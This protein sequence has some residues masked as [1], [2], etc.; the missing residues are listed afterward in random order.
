M[1]DSR[2]FRMSPSA[3]ELNAHEMVC[4]GKRSEAKSAGVSL[5]F[6]QSTVKTEGGGE[7]DP[8]YVMDTGR[9][10]RRYSTSASRRR[11]SSTPIPGKGET[12]INYS[13][14][15]GIRLTTFDSAAEID[16]LAEETPSPDRRPTPPQSRYPRRQRGPVPARTQVR[17][18]PGRGGAALETRARCGDRRR[19][20]SFHVG[21]A[22]SNPRAFG[23]AIALARRAFDAAHELGLPKLQVLDIGGGF[24]VGPNFENAARTIT[25]AL[26]SHFADF[27]SDLTVIAE[28][29]RFFSETAFTLATN[30]I[31]KR[32]RGDL[33]EYWINDGIY[34]SMN[35]ILYDKATINAV[36]LACASNPGNHSCTG[37]KTHGATVFGPTC[38]ALDT[39][40]SDYRLPELEVHDWLVFPIM[41]AYTAAAGSN[42]NGF[43]TAATGTRVAFFDPPTLPA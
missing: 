25:A 36:P 10:W 15:V 18:P 34:G 41:G 5:E 33:R 28:P 7:R 40:L 42:F 2:V 11:T 43:S 29:G 39:V 16:K 1:E 14:A 27:E 35:C 20:V 3:V 17:R 13:A 22:A 19:G 8:F 30:I 31:G 21:S 12:H 6:I 37:M 26:S 9:R 23:E 24:I 32:V 38:D 4:M